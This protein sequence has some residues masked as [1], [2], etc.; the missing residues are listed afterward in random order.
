MR[1]GTD[2]L[3]FILAFCLFASVAVAVNSKMK[4]GENIAE[5]KA[6]LELK[7]IR[8]EELEKE[9]RIL[10]TDLS[11]KENGFPEK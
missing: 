9:I 10:K 6:Q 11:I 2:V 1:K 4:E 3:S 8:I 7:D 5:Y